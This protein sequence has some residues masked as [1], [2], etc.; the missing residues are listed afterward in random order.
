MKVFFTEKKFKISPFRKVIEKLFAFGQKYKDENND[1][2]HLL[3]KLVMNRLY[4]ER[5]REDTEESLPI[6]QNIGL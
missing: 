1:V 3:V 2:K 6:N 4:G 5:I